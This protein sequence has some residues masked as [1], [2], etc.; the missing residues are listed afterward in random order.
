[1]IKN[2]NLNNR[3]IVQAI[4]KGQIIKAVQLVRRVHRVN[5]SDAKE[6]VENIQRMLSN[7]ENNSQSMSSPSARLPDTVESKL[8]LDNRYTVSYQHSHKHSIEKDLPTEVFLLLQQGHTQ[9]AIKGLIRIKGLAPTSAKRLVE[10]FYRENP[11]YQAK[12]RSLAKPTGSNFI[13]WDWLLA[14]LFLGLIIFLNQ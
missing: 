2:S 3:K 8:T 12:S 14:F 13:K 5:L 1:M 6:M 11:Q 10:M 7:S 4:Q 9:E